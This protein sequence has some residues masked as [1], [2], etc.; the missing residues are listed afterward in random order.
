MSY[1][2]NLINRALSINYSFLEIYHEEPEILELRIDNMSIRQ[3]K[4]QVKKLKNITRVGL[5]TV[6]ADEFEQYKLILS[7]SENEELKCSLIDKS[8]KIIKTQYLKDPI[9]ESVILQDKEN[10]VIH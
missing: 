3:I 7:Y 2:Q 4:S 5:V 10:N 1:H 9:F 6:E 8:N